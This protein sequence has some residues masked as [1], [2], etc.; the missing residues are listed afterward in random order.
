MAWEEQRRLRA[1]RADDTLSM[2]R[3]AI[4]AAAPPDGASSPRPGSARWEH[5]GQ[6]FGWIA[7]LGL[8]VIALGFSVAA[9]ANSGHA[10]HPG[11]GGRPGDGFA[12]HGAYGFGGGDGGGQGAPRGMPTP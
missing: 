1:G 3:G 2:D 5:W 4:A 6:R 11:P 7:A 12:P 9:F 10:G 8:A